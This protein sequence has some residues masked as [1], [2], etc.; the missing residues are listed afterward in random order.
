MTHRDF[1][2]DLA[3]QAGAIIRKNFTLGMKKEWKQDQSPLTATDLVVNDLVIKSIRERYPDHGIITE[4]AREI[5]G[6]GEHTWVCDPIDGTIPFSHGIP[7]S[8][9]SIS[10]T[11]SGRPVLAVIYDPFMDRLFIGE[12][13][14]GA[15]LNGKKIS[16]SSATSLKNTYLAT[17]FPRV[18]VTD[19]SQFI[20]PL[21]QHGAGVLTL[22]VIVYP[23][24]L[25]ASGELVATIFSGNKPWDSAALK[26]IVEGAGGKVTDLFGHEQRYDQD[27]RGHLATSGLS[28]EQILEIIRQAKPIV[29]FDGS[30]VKISSPS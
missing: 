9:F 13:G 21:V 23:G 27:V 15:T 26:V 17:G 24:A 8:C 29:D 10:L 25:V 11:R 22:G 6:T 14:K 20:V 30:L 3:K 18:S 1:A 28:H 5:Q 4:E 7:I 16:V 12:G 2:I 19:A